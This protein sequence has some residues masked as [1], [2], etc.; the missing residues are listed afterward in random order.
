VN[1]LQW[2]WRLLVECFW[3][4]MGD[5]VS[6]FAGGIGPLR[7]GCV[8]SSMVEGPNRHRGSTKETTLVMWRAHGVF[9]L[10]ERGRESVVCIGGGGLLSDMFIFGDWH[11][12]RLCEASVTAFTILVR[13]LG[14]CLSLH[15]SCV[16]HHLCRSRVH[17]WY[18]EL[19]LVLHIAVLQ[20]WLCVVMFVPIS[21]LS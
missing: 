16:P 12:R 20:L 1:L 15:V 2:W 21:F 10:Y 6:S 5:G 14:S 3:S 7:C 9:G 4:S 11:G 13:D 18:L 17:R 8:G 19:T